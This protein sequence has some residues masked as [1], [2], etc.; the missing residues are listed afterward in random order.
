MVLLWSHQYTPNVSIYIPYMDPM[1]YTPLKSSTRG[2]ENCS[3]DFFRHRNGSLHKKAS[4]QEAPSITQSSWRPGKQQ[5]CEHRLPRPPPP[6]PP[7]QR[8]QQLPLPLLLPTPTFTKDRAWISWV[9]CCENHRACRSTNCPHKNHDLRRSL[10]DLN[11]LR[12]KCGRCHGL[13]AGLRARN[14]A[15][16]KGWK[17]VR[18]SPPHERCPQ[19]GS[20]KGATGA[21]RRPGKIITALTQTTAC[22]RQSPS[23]I[24]CA[25]FGVVAW[26]FYLT[27][28][29]GSPR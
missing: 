23:T 19:N 27:L 22:H 26:V 12:N 20:P 16:R 11:G 6:Q 25:L 2:L 3:N 17:N 14:L 7:R 13:R 29:P 18:M 15:L 4:F 1:G 10:S 28:N 8:Q 5:F 9:P 21:M 24:R